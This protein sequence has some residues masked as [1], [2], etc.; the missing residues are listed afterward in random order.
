[1]KAPT[2]SLGTLLRHLAELLDG[3]V[4]DS[5]Q[6]AGLDYR[7]RFTPVIRALMA[8]GPSSIR[9]IADHAGITH[10][11]ASQ[12]VAQMTLQKWVK[13]GRGG[14]GRERIVSLTAHA[15]R[16]VTSLEHCWAATSIAAAD[17]ERGLSAPLSQVLREAIDALERRPFSARLQ[18]AHQKLRKR[19]GMGDAK[20]PTPCL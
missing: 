9:A 13:Y 10:S 18:S 1:M 2:A 16:K 3:A 8:L 11:A 14:D 4:E 5:Y 6:Q 15:E 12:T 7:P 20:A 17:L 19:E